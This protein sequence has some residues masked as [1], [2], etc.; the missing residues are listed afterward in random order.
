MSSLNVLGLGTKQV[1]GES[2]SL[3]FKKLKVQLLSQT[4]YNNTNNYSTDSLMQCSLI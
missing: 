2:T 3:D 4:K 1:S